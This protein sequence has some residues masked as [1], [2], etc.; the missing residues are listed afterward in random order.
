MLGTETKDA[1]IEKEK[2]FASVPRSMFTGFRCFIGECT[3]AE[4]HSI[5]HLLL[6]AYGAAFAVSYTASMLI[7][8]FG[9]FNLIMAIYVENTVRAAKR[10]DQNNKIQRERE[11]LRVAQMAR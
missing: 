1:T 10:S 11:A 9:L 6:D 4:G 3:T 2:L 7:V 8:T 5:P